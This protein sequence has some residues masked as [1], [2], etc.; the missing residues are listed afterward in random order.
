[1]LC[2]TAAHGIKGL[3]KS[4]VYEE[5]NKPFELTKSDLDKIENYLKGTFEC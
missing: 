5:S 4:E 2:A 1:M 3:R